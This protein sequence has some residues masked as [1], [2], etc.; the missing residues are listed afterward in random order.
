VTAERR[1]AIIDV[2]SLGLLLGLALALRTHWSY[3][4]AF[5]DEAYTLNSG[6]QLVRGQTT[7]APSVY[8]GWEYLTTVPLALADSIGGLVAA[9]AVN[10]FWG[11][12]TV[13]MVTL[14]GRKIFGRP[15]GLIAGGILAVFGPA[16]FI[17]TF[18]TYDSLSVF[19]ISLALYVWLEALLG[20]RTFLYPL[21]SVIIVLAVLTK[22]AAL[23]SALPAAVFFAVITLARMTTVSRS[24]T[25]SVTINLKLRSFGQIIA[26]ALPLILLPV[27]VVIFQNDLFKL[28]QT[29]V[30]TKR[31]DVPGAAWEMFKQSRDYLGLPF[32]AGLLA[33]DWRGLRILATGLLMT[34]LGVLGYHFLSR[35]VSTL[36][37]HTC[38]VLVAIAPLAGG[39]IV[40]LT[41]RWNTAS[42]RKTAI[43][44]AVA[45]G[46]AVVGYVGYQG[47]QVL[48]G[49]RSFWPDTT[50]VVAYLAERINDDDILLMEYGAVGRYYLIT[51]G[52]PGHIPR[53][54]WDTWWYADEEGEGGD[55]AVFERAIRQRRFAYIILDNSV[56]ADLNR[57]LAPTI[58][59][60]YEL[61]ASFPA[62]TG[63][64]KR[65]DVFRRADE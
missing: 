28:W 53:Y 7:Y 44:V 12:L 52:E 58:E 32:L 2:V 63:D 18:A 43:V 48:S 14:I 19:L 24:G 57:R 41:Q 27:Y 4:T 29:Q 49:M 54:V 16:I 15:A 47:Q 10:T 21:G 60:H 56:T 65:I 8:M 40:S 11:V 20:D 22:Y 3:R 51:H 9:R 30:L 38:Y 34:G 55:V 25:D 62:R 5:A 1:N 36:Y 59:R 26:M 42:A 13:L 64:T 6:W 61:V 37:K 45:T 33:F 23:S 17:S 39:G 31:V 35:D 50:E 46:A